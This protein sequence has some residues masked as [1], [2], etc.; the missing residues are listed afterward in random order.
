[1]GQGRSGFNIHVKWLREAGR[2][3]KVAAVADLLPE[4]HEAVAELGA[5]GF[6]DYRAMLGDKGLQLDLVV[7]ALPTHLHT[8]GAIAA[9]QAGYHVVSEKPFALTLAD[10]DATVAAAKKSG[11]R[12]FPFQNSRYSPGFCKIQEVLA[13]GKLGRLIQARIHYSNHGRRWDWQCTQRCG[14]GNLN[15]TGPHPVDQ[16]VMLFGEKTPQVFSKLMSVNPWG[17]ADNFAAVT[18]HGPDSPLVEVS[19]SSFM[20]YPCGDT[21][22]L[23]CEY[24]GLTGNSTSLKWRYFDPAKAPT[25]EPMPGWSDKRSYNHEKLEWV[26]ETWVTAP[27]LEA[28]QQ[29]SQGFYDEVYGCLVNGIEPRVTL[30]QVRRQVGVIEECH[31]QNPLPV[32]FGF[33]E[34]EPS[35]R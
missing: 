33:M 8:Q 19:V 32:K 34:R 6:T 35:G 4:R 31:R 12:V 7:N 26:E 13:S 3:F 14:G 27:V 5:K 24:G 11:R 16:A 15:N 29:M 17:D 20:A 28:F 10:F 18:L 21:Y 25:H 30:E 2:Q 1:M 22:N 23:S 9:L